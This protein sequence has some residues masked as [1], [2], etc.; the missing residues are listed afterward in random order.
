MAAASILFGMGLAKWNM[1]PYR[2][3]L[4]I[5]RTVIG[6]DTDRPRP[7]VNYYVRRTDQFDR[8]P[9]GAD[10]LVIGDSLVEQGEWN[11][12]LAP[13]AVHNRGIGNDTVYGLSL[14][15]GQTCRHSYKTGILMIGVNDALNGILESDFAARYRALLHELAACTLH[16]VVHPIIV[17]QR[18]KAVASRV[19]AYNQQITAIAQA[20]GATIV[21]LNPILAPGGTLAMEYSDDGLHLNGRG[22]LLWAEALKAAIR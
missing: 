13:L 12:L 11:E 16:Q 5:A 7:A 4:T 2:A 17:P 14:R 18:S 8:L 3:A 10:V 19:A 9:G 1:L 6:L 22:Y 20:N 15:M 21:D